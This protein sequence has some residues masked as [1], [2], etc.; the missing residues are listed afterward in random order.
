MPKRVRRA[1]KAGR[2]RQ[3]EET[4]Y[5]EELGREAD[6]KKLWNMYPH[7]SSWLMVG[8]LTMMSVGVGAWATS[9]Y[10]Q[11]KDTTKVTTGLTVTAAENK[12]EIVLLKREDQI[13]LQMISE[14]KSSIDTI[15]QDVKKLLSRTR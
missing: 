7:L 12:S 9:V 15:Q 2:Q 3:R 6:L 10:G 5:T 1:T 14:M 11:I 8:L 4:I 13:H